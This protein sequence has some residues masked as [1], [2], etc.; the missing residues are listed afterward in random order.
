MC[1]IVQLYSLWKDPEGLRVFSSPE[2]ELSSEVF[3]T[4]AVLRKEVNELQQE[5]NGVIS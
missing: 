5:L 2:P 4:I 3:D 1:I